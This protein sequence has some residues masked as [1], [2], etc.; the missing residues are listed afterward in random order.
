MG[1]KST[2]RAFVLSSSLTQ[3]RTLPAPPLSS[4]IHLSTH[5][6][7]SPVENRVEALGARGSA[8][9]QS[10]LWSAQCLLSSLLTRY[11]CYALVGYGNV[12]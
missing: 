1:S 4:I 12:W 3:Q 10:L 5:S 2:V 6:H 9:A 8:G 7:I 11:K